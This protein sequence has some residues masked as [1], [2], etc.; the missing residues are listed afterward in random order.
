MTRF[1][2]TFSTSPCGQMAIWKRPAFWLSG[3]LRPAV[4]QARRL[5]A[6]GRGC[7]KGRRVPFRELFVGLGCLASTAGCW[8]SPPASPNAGGSLSRTEH[9]AAG[10]SAEDTEIHF[11]DVADSSGVVWVGR[12]GEEAGR[13][14]M[15]ESFGTGCAVDDYDRDGQLDLFFAGGGEFGPPPEILPRP[16][17]LYRQISAWNFSPVAPVARL[18]PVRHYNHGTWTADIDEDG[19]SDLLLTGWGGLQLFHNQGDGTFAD[20]TDAAGLHDAMWSLAAGWA[21]LNRDHILDLFVGHYVN[22]SFENHPA[23]IDGRHGQRDVCPPNR[24]RGLPCTAYVSNGDGTY[25]D[26]SLELG[27]HEIGKTLGVVIADLNGDLQP[28]LYVANDTVP[29]QFYQSQPGGDYRE[30]AIAN[31]VA[32]GETGASDGSMGVELADL[33]GDGNPDLW[34]ANYENQTFALYRNLG[35]DNFSH[36]SRA[37]GVTAVGSEAVG[38]GTVVLDADGDGRPDIFCA[39]GH[40]TAPG[41]PGERRQKPYLFWNDHGRRLR[42]I[43]SRAGS[44][45]EQR[46][47]GRGAAGGDLDGDGAPDLVVAHTNEPAALLRNDTQI[48]NWLSVEL[49]G[50]SS[51]RSAI[52]ARVKIVAGGVRQTGLI[53]GG[54]SYLSTSDRRIHFGLGTATIV[55]HVEVHW[56][57][58][59]IT[60]LASVPS[61]RCLRVTEDGPGASVELQ[62]KAD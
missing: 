24:F 61:G 26:A 30:V 20:Q 28:D 15:L 27:I 21:D 56:P 6:T 33:D 23:C 25:R 35:G 12:N 40:V 49:I 34:V 38:F 13:F 32:F 29:N 39:N 11:T 57:A 9:S 46:H 54:G 22:W 42:N 53:K 10:T 48:S 45:F 55:D 50:R 19:F 18:E 62:R 4:R 17:G 8:T 37:F 44:Y 43:A 58:G 59:T 2:G 60:K 31:G 41:I 52:G 14:A 36:A 47:L 7:G 1:L 51:P 3:C 5:R 16:I